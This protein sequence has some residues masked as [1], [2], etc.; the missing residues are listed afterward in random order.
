MSNSETERSHVFYNPDGYVEMTLVGTVTAAQI[1]LLAE[2]AK[3]LI[4]QHGPVGGL[5]DGRRG[6]IVRNVETLTILRGL[7]LPQ[8]T[9]LVILTT[10][11]NPEGIQ[12]PSVVMSILTLILGFRPLYIGDESQA[13]HLAAN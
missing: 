8:L 3:A 6:N 4:Q 9:R 11:D 13:R 2:A 7:Q 1:R 5:I 12:G 10:A